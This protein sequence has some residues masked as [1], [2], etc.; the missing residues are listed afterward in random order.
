MAKGIKVL[1]TPQEFQEKG[2]DGETAQ[3]MRKDTNTAIV[4]QKLGVDRHVVRFK[5]L[6]NLSAYKN[7]FKR[8]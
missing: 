8:F 7:P 4:G 2:F 1:Y 6:H 5:T 3:L